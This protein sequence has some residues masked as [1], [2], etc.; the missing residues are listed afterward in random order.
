MG[1][2]KMAVSENF[3]GKNFWGLVQQDGPWKMT[4]R[5]YNNSINRPIAPGPAGSGQ[6]SNNDQTIS[7]K[8]RFSKRG[9]I[10]TPESRYA[11]YSIVNRRGKSIVPAPNPY[12][13]PP[14]TRGYDS[15]QKSRDIGDV[16]DFLDIKGNEFGASLGSEF[17]DKPL[18]PKGGLFVTEG[19]LRDQAIK[20]MIAP[21]VELQSFEQQALAEDFYDHMVSG[22][23]MLPKVDVSTKR[24]GPNLLVSSVIGPYDSEYNEHYIPPRMSLFEQAMDTHQHLQAREDY[25]IDKFVGLHTKLEGLEEE[26]LD[27]SKAAF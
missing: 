6:Y 4:G 14:G 16:Q 10:T 20:Q 25:L 7:F 24:L 26:Q 17:Y 22:V 12:F 1:L 23:A 3:V 15:N 18:Y 11:Q 27:Q 9:D 13:A 8:D 21:Q 19:Y 5:D 2:N